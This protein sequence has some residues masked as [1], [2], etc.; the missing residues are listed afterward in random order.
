MQASGI[1]GIA[2]KYEKVR[3]YEMICNT[4]SYF[5]KI[6]Y[7]VALLRGRFE[8]KTKKTHLAKF[9]G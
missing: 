1:V 6:S 7:F 4:F 8:G 3:N 2:T 9:T 5:R